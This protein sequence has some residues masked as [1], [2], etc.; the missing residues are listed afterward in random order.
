[1]DI[2]VTLSDDY[3]IETLTKIA[4][5]N[6]LSVDQYS[7]NIIVGW[8]REQIRGLYINKTR[9]ATIAELAASIGKIDVL[10]KEVQQITLKEDI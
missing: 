10:T 6:G 7:T 8:V 2:K 1:M 4:T 9:T 5:S 3:E